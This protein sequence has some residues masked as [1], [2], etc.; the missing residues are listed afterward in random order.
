MTYNVRQHPRIALATATVALGTLWALAAPGLAAAQPAPFASTPVWESGPANL[1]RGAA[2]GDLDRDGKLDLVCAT[3]AQPNELYRGE[4]RWFATSSSWTPPAAGTATV[5][6]GDVDGDGDLDV[7]CGIAGKNTLY[8]NDDGLLGTTPSWTSTASVTTLCVALADVDNDGDLDLVCAE[9][10]A[11]VSLFLNTGGA[12]EEPAAWTSTRNQTGAVALGD[13]DGDGNLDLVCGNLAGQENALYRNVGGTFEAS[14]SWTSDS[15]FTTTAVRLGDING[16]GRLDLVCANRASNTAYLNVGATFDTAPAWVS[17]PQ[18]L[19]LS[20]DLGDV[21]LDGDL[22]AVFGNEAGVNT[23]YRNTGGALELDPSWSSGRSD[24]TAGLVLADGDG[25][26]DLDLVCCNSN[27][28][29]VVYEN[30]SP[31]LPGAADWV[32]TNSGNTL[33]IVLGDVTGDGRLDLVC[34]NLGT[35]TMYANTGTVFGTSPSWFT[36]PN[37]LT[38]GVDLGDVDGDGDVDLA[39]GNAT[40]NTLY[41]NDNGM[42]GTTPVWTSGAAHTTAS[43]AFGDIDGNGSLDLVCAN[44]AVDNTIYFNQGGVLADTAGWT[45]ATL[46]AADVALGDVDGD[47]DLDVVFANTDDTPNTLH[48][49]DGGLVTVAPAWSS[50]P[51]NKSGSLALGDVDGDGRVDVVF[52]N[53]GQANTLYLN[54]GDVFATAPAWSSGLA[55]LTSSV[56]LGD[57]DGDGDLDLACGN[58]SEPNVIYINI[59]TTLAT[60]PSWTS[61][62]S[63]LTEDVAFAD[64]DGDGDLDLVCG[65]QGEPDELYLGRRNPPYRGD[66]ATPTAHLVN[67]AAFVSG[68]E[69]TA[70]HANVRDMRFTLVDV[71]SD[72]VWLRAEYQFDGEPVWY[73]AD[74]GGGPVAGPFA[75]S[76]A[77]VADSL[78]WLVTLLPFDARDVTLRMR[79]IETPSRVGA[80]QRIPSFLASVGRITPARPEIAPSADSVDFATVTVGDTVSVSLDVTNRG[81]VPLVIGDIALPSPE[82]SL[83]TAPPLFIMPNATVSLGFT[84]APVLEANVGGYIEIE[85]NDAITPLDSIAV[86]SDIRALAVTTRLLAGAPAIPLGEAA[87]VVVEPLPQVHVEAG[88]LFHRVAGA[89]TFSSIPLA[90]SGSDLVALIPG[91]DVGEGGIEY[92]VEVDNAPVT[93]VDPPGAPGD[94]LFYQAVESPASV[95]SSPRPTAGGDFGEGLDI[96]VDVD[97][98]QGAEFVDGT[99]HYRRGGGGS[100]ATVPITVSGDK[101]SATIDGSTVGPRGVEYWVGVETRTAMLT[102]PPVDP[103]L[104]PAAIRVTVADLLEPTVHKGGVYRLFSVP[105]EMQGSILG[106]LAD[107]LGGKD[108]T[109]WRLFAFDPELARYDEIPSAAEARFTRGKA[110]WLITLDAHRIGTGDDVGRTTPTDRAFDVTLEPGYNLVANPYDFDVAWDDFVVNNVAATD[111]LASALV[112]PPVAWIPER[113]YSFDASTLEPFDGYWVKNV[114]SAPVVLH[115]PRSEAPAPAPGAAAEADAMAWSVAVEAAAAGATSAGAWLGV[116]TGASDAWD[117]IDRSAPPAPPG[118]SLSVYFPHGEWES[119]P[120]RYARDARAGRAGDGHVWRF[121]VAKSYSGEPGGDEVTVSLAG[122]DDVPAE[123]E[124]ALVDRELG[125]SVDARAGG[126]LRSYVGR[127]GVVARADDARFAVVAGSAEF[128]EAQARALAS[129]PRQ[130]V[131]LQNHPN[132]FNPRTVIRYDLAEPA[133]VILRVYDV[134]GALV[135]TLEDRDRPAGRYEVGWD[136][137]ND[138]G[139]RVASGVY[140]YRI[141]AGPFRATRKMVLLK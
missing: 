17:N 96:V 33:G 99:L 3:L 53:V 62:G 4:G 20:V 100:Y 2:V 76:P 141:V 106:S 12:F 9:S 128:V 52:G 114:T 132:P 107:E 81:N 130:T 125:R 44:A 16:D 68:L 43:V 101:P 123:F 72:P 45:A 79:A 137:L 84:L 40:A 116:G 90:W 93:S 78:R 41:R 102:D 37:A 60:S 31:P 32:S 10:A 59:G 1:T 138:R 65:N 61:V 64:V 127:R 136:G 11:G 85:S 36:V 42:L 28:T 80:V 39:C 108:N 50:I 97:L 83:D 38:A 133:R 48:R 120:G 71:E 47:G 34:G 77:G 74:V 126:V 140:F 70:P 89:S 15:T 88:R 57:V 18:H 23:F 129:A 13:V 121:D 118:Q 25:D 69:V 134:R 66:P 82:M 98:P 122:L 111:T 117:S 5:A 24:D 91:A 105:L 67:N 103:S 112:E 110:Y 29:N 75:T 35:N 22:D 94:S 54:E 55:Q 92:Y 124:V 7:V 49:N 30:V 26:G 119:H 6:V 51:A 113:G 8:I 109:K 21:D 58:R 73:P 115:F 87:T 135:R 95:A 27:Q 14:P 46:G 131:L 56:A 86:T 139:E 63:G 104:S 19:A